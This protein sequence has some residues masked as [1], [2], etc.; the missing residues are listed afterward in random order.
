MAGR[1]A[2]GQVLTLSVGTWEGGW[3]RGAGRARGALPPLVSNTRG[4]LRSGRPRRPN[5]TVPLGTLGSAREHPW[6]KAPRDAASPPMLPL[7]PCTMGYSPA[8]RGSPGAPEALA[9]QRRWDHRAGCCLARPSHPWDLHPPCHPVG[10]HSLRV[11]GWGAPR[12]PKL[13]WVLAPRA[14]AS[15]QRTDLPAGWHRSDSDCRGSGLRRGRGGER[16]VGMGMSHP[17][18]ASACEDWPP[19]WGSRGSGIAFLSL[20][21]WKL[22]ETCGEQQRDAVSALQ[23]PSPSSNGGALPFLPP[24][25]PCRGSLNC[26][27]GAGRGTPPYRGRLAAQDGP[28]R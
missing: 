13:C 28:S 8:A 16:R 14:T 22:V 24:L 6:S 1:D 26:P 2:T 17:L 7:A 19:T 5:D 11:S 3:T 21:S 18:P 15:G 27:E 9:A 23:H 25:P 20:L 4:A 10:W 12:Y